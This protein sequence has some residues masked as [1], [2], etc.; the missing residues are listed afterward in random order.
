[1]F[2]LLKLLLIW[3]LF[4][5][6][7]GLI[8]NP[9]WKTRTRLYSNTLNDY[10]LRPSAT[11]DVTTRLADEE[12]LLAISPA[13]ALRVAEVQKVLE[14][15]VCQVTQPQWKS[16]KISQSKLGI[17]NPTRIDL[18]QVLS[19][20]FP[21]LLIWISGP[22]MSMV[23]TSAVGLT[24]GLNELA[25]L[26]PATG[27]T[28][29][30]LYCFTFLSVVVTNLVASALVRKDELSAQRGVEDGVLV[31]CL[32]G[33]LTSA[34]LLSPLGSVALNFFTHAG[35]PSAAA[36]F[37]IALSYVRIRA[38]GVV[39]V[40]CSIVY[41]SACLARRDTKLPLIA[42]LASVFANAVGD[43][44]LVLG[45]GQGAAGTAWATV[46]AQVASWI[47]LWRNEVKVRRATKQ[48]CG[49][50][51]RRSIS[52][53]LCSLRFFMKRSLAPAFALASKGSITMCLMATASVCGTVGV[54]AHQ[55]AYSIF[56]LFV[57]FGEALGQTVQA[58]LPAVN[59]EP[60]GG[61]PPKGKLSE[62]GRQFTNKL[63]QAA[64][65]I[66]L[67]A[68]FAAGSLPLFASRFF[69]TDA[70]VGLQLQRLSPYI[71]GITLFHALNTTLEGILFTSGDEN[72]LGRVYPLSCA[73][74]C[75]LMFQL[76][77]RSAPLTQIWTLLC[78][79]HVTR[80]STF[81]ARA[82]M[83][84]RDPLTVSI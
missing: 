5:C 24:A 31:A 63:A 46:L 3:C 14:A 54:A 13:S 72:F 50:L 25:A 16:T 43:V 60:D 4:Q 19:M 49:V 77:Q 28:D 32:L 7:F 53:R 2:C 22:I 59:V 52:E 56:L 78:G 18:R 8:P 23:D 34:I 20:T 27:L 67:L 21:L 79:F 15:A 76:R 33:S 64:V 73:I 26:G 29:M 39:P 81:L 30:T 1:M 36:Y 10:G 69:T 68:A 42:V 71:F 70:A 65:G 61:S 82:F 17:E 40:L 35:G 44:F 37:G 80:V 45:C 51:P 12:L 47:V 84:Q 83:N 62:A 41:M 6:S 66:G 57:P 48:L 55:V 9:R 38:L 58:L 74:M 11:E 75:V